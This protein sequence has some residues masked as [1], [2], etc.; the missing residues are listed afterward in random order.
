MTDDEY[1]R[2]KQ[3]L[4]ASALLLGRPGELPP[5]W[6]YSRVGWAT[7]TVVKSGYARVCV[8]ELFDCA[9]PDFKTLPAG[10]CQALVDL[11][12]PR[13]VDSL[14]GEVLYGTPPTDL[15]R[16]MMVEALRRVESLQR[17]IEAIV[18]GEKP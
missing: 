6:L 14:T 11:L 4:R 5:K 1:Q 16:E 8:G 2:H 9:V 17:Q 15:G 18:Q 13:V 7:H 3:Q 12:Y 10:K